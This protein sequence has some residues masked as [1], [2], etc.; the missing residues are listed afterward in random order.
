LAGLISVGRLISLVGRLALLVG[1]L[2]SPI[3][4]LIALVA[5]LISPIYP[6]DSGFDR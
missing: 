4:R 6:A 2:I 1:W 3:S 5:W